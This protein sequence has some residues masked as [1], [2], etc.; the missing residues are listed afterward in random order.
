MRKIR[1]NYLKLMKKIR[2]NGLHHKIKNITKG[3]R[4]IRSL[5]IGSHK[6]KNEK[7]KKKKLKYKYKIKLSSNNRGEVFFF[8]GFFLK[9]FVFRFYIFVC[10]FFS[11]FA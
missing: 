9:Q 11:K 10:F 5:K 7:K 6:K 1:E 3:R 2:E 8:F 4:N